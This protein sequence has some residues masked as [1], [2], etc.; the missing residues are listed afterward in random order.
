MRAPLQ[1][2]RTTKRDV[3]SELRVPLQKPPENRSAPR[4]G[5]VAGIDNLRR[6]ASRGARGSP[7]RNP[8]RLRYAFPDPLVARRASRRRTGSRQFR[9]VGRRR[10][11]E[12]LGLLSEI[13]ESLA[14]ILGAGGMRDLASVRPQMTFA[15]ARHV[16]LQAVLAG[17]CGELL[18]GC[19]LPSRQRRIRLPIRLRD[20]LQLVQ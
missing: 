5:P 3:S 8:A 2:S 11:Q 15:P 19:A 17:G 12:L 9:S 14:G 7:L 18:S 16:D 1:R 13:A 20:D 10:S 4:R 6:Q